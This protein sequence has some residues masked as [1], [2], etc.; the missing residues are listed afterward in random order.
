MREVGSKVEG[1]LYHDVQKEKGADLSSLI[2]FLSRVVVTTF[3][4]QLF[5]HSACTDSATFVF[6]STRTVST[7]VSTIIGKYLSVYLHIECIDKT[8]RRCIDIGTS[9]ALI[10]R[11]KARSLFVIW[12]P[13]GRQVLSY[14][15]TV[16]KHTV[17]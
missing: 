17:Q 16:F 13:S 12:W 2:I 10:N 11:D 6:S 4:V 9:S 8:Y 3:A 7:L 1:E 15:A 14:A 5:V